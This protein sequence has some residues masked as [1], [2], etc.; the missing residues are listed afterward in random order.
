MCDVCTHTHQ[1]MHT[2]TCKHNVITK[3][4]SEI[5]R[6]YN[7]D[8]DWCEHRKPYVGARCMFQT[9]TEFLGL[10]LLYFY[11]VKFNAIQL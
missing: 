2:Y 3:H 4:A 7:T 1:N 11:Y 8:L 10:I 9:T 5:A 6:Q